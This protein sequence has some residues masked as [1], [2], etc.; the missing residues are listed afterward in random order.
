MRPWPWPTWAP[1]HALRRRQPD[2]PLSLY[3]VG[4]PGGAP[5]AIPAADPPDDL[6]AFTAPGSIYG[7]LFP[8]RFLSLGWSSLALHWLSALPQDRPPGQAW[9]SGL[10][11]DARAPYA[12]RAAADWLGFLRHRAAELRPGGGLVV[13]VPAR[14]EAGCWALRPLAERISAVLAAMV[15]RGEL[16]PAEHGRM[17][18]PVYH[19]SREE[20]VRPFGDHRLGLRLEAH[21]LDRAA[22]PHWLTYL[23]GGSAQALGE[24][25][26]ALACR[27][28]GPWLA[29]DQGRGEGGRWAFLAALEAG[30]RRD[31]AAAP[32]PLAM[33][34]VMTLWI[35]KTA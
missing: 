1:P 6:Y 17:V 35:A 31:V 25:Y 29:K 27:R 15:E 13:Q 22:E 34:P 18:V 23:S 20:L 7:R 33:A 10:D 14:D 28:F 16:T 5:S 12:C 26:A 8:P 9:P 2:L 24:A 30:L 21:R 11:G 19:R 32:A 4:H 3:R